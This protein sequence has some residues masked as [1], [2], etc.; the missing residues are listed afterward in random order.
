M[1]V[2][3][4]K[5]NYVDVVVDLEGN[6]V[7]VEEFLNCGLAAVDFSPR[8]AK[9]KMFGSQFN[10]VIISKEHNSCENI[11]KPYVDA[12]EVSTYSDSDYENYKA[13][14]TGQSS[15]EEFVCEG[16][17]FTLKKNE[18]RNTVVC[19]EGCKCR[20]HDSLVQGGPTFQL[21]T[22]KGEHNCARRQTNS[23]A[24]YKYLSKIIESIVRENCDIKIDRLRNIIM[25]KCDVKVHKWKVLRAKNA[26]LL[27][28]RR[29]NDAQYE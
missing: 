7:D 25:R 21:K 8:E 6:Y 17:E 9:N 27:S 4:P 12:P 23:L 22:L 16:Y 5:R 20:V 11:D 26:D 29:V 1:D 19:K 18:S 3:D 24:N 28:I 10:E 15:S 14:D 13:S 2:V